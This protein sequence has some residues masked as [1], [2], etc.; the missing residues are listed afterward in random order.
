M[1]GRSDSA[2]TLDAYLTATLDE[3]LKTMHDN[4]FNR[5]VMLSWL[6]GTLGQ[7]TRGGSPKVS[8]SS[9]ND[10]IVPLMYGKNTTVKS[11][12]GAELLDTT[13]QD[14]ITN[15]KFSWAYYSGSVGLLGKEKRNNK[16]K[17]AILNLL[18][19]KMT[20]LEMSFADKL[21]G[22]LLASARASSKDVSALKDII[23]TSVTV[24]GLAPGTYTWWKAYADTSVGG[25][26]S[27]G[28]GMMR[29]AINTLN[30]RGGKGCDLIFTHQDVFEDYEDTQDGLK[31]YESKMVADAGFTS[32]TFK[33][34]PM[35]FDAAAQ[36]GEMY[37]LNS[38]NVKWE[39][40]KE[41]D[42]TM[43]PEGFQ[44]PIG[45]DVT[46]AKILFQGNVTVNNR[47][48]LGVATGIS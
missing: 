5:R 17:H 21:N 42:M 8:H 25:F 26:S 23:S 47:R 32:L 30:S 38:E 35:T 37:F 9:G 14:G 13:L 19:S 4:I 6:N 2:R 36:S 41:A 15:A 39:V 24:G 22:H 12:D 45:Q 29:T 28:I 1:A 33:G 43:S 3:Y 31:R 7:A 40:H 44:T 16:G 48:R 10:I 18:Q 46:T 34:I 27:N 20:Q 11:Y